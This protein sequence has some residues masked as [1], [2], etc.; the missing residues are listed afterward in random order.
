MEV[1]KNNENS[2]NS[3]TQI[4]FNSFIEHWAKARIDGPMQAIARYDDVAKLLITIGGF[5]QTV[6]VAIYSFMV[7]ELYASNTPV[8]VFWMKTVSVVIFL[9]LLL[10]FICAAAVCF[11][12][13]SIQAK[14]I[15]KYKGNEDLTE[16]I[17]RW[18]KNINHTINIKRRL[19]ISA[20]FFF[21]MSFL[22]M[23]ALLLDLLNIRK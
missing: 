21:I 20:T 7:K 9:S 1:K 15:L 17:E 23:I 11:P 6:L 22:V 13:P 10:F 12:Q 19:L 2:K 5:L 3:E 18:C 14:E 4:C 16:D 8:N